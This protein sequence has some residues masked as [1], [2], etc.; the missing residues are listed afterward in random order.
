MCT[1]DAC[2]A[3]QRGATCAKLRRAAAISGTDLGGGLWDTC[4]TRT[5]TIAF[6]GNCARSAVDFFELSSACATIVTIR[7]Q[8]TPL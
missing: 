6:R 5:Y 2:S 7:Y 4:S 1:S 3:L 8:H